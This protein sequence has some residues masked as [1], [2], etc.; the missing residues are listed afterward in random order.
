MGLIVTAE[1]FYMGNAGPVRSTLPDAGMPVLTA[2]L[3]EIEQM[4][5]LASGEL[6]A[7]LHRIIN[8]EELYGWSVGKSLEAVLQ[9]DRDVPEN[10]LILET[11]ERAFLPLADR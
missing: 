11:Y 10:S 8:D 2:S 3:R 7:A 9:V 5:V 6:G 1:P 4:S